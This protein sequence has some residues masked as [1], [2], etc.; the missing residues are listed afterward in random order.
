MLPQ[1]PSSNDFWNSTEELAL[2]LSPIAN[3]INVK[4]FWKYPLITWAN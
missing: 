3:C 2:P 4:V 1:I